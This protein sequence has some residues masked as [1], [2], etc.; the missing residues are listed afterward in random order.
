MN[1]GDDADTVGAIY[2]QLAGAYYGVSAIP[3]EWKAKCSLTPLIELFA[4]ELVRLADSITAP[5]IPTY[6]S[7]DWTAEYSP[8][9][10]EKCKYV[11]QALLT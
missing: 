6:H 10:R 11:S 1:L 3:E 4:V 7:T 8:V 2:G 5:D 9:V